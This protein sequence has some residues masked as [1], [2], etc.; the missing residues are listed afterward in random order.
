MLTVGSN[1][2][3]NRLEKKTMAD[4]KQNPKTEANA[5]ADAKAK[6]EAKR[7]LKTL[8]KRIGIRITNLRVKRGY[9]RDELAEKVGI[10]C[11]FLY[12]IEG[13]KKGFSA[14]TLYR[15]SNALG[16]SMDYIITGKE[17][18]GIGGK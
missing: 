10:S 5:K 16:I 12:E 18:K 2:K 4:T 6:T 17:F 3:I 14:L 11:K 9:T 1:K 8:D 15:L 7:K 13:N